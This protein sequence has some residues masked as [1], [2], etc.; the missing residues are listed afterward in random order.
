MTPRSKQ[1]ILWLVISI[2]VLA[3]L[4]MITPR[5]LST[6]VEGE[7][8]ERIYAHN[9]KV[10]KV[11]VDL[12]ARSLWLHDLEWSS[13]PDT[14]NSFPHI[15]R[16]HSIAV[17]R[18]SLYQ[19]IKNKTI[20]IREIVLDS[21]MVQPNSA[22]KRISETLESTFRR[23]ECSSIVLNAVEVEIMTDTIVSLSARI[24]LQLKDIVVS[25]DTSN[26][27]QYSIKN[28]EGTAYG[29]QLSRHEGMYGGTIR[30]LYISTHEGRIEFDSV[31]LIPNYT[32]YRFAQILG[33]QAGR[34]NISIP[35]LI[36]EGVAFEKIPDSAFIVSKVS[37]RSLDLFS[38]K[39]K[40]VP[41][42]R[43]YTIPLPM[44]GFLS[45]KWKV[46][47]D[48]VQLLDSRIIIEE[49][50]EKGDERT[51]ITFSDVNALLTGL[52]NQKPENEENYAILKATGLLMG[53]GKIE[54]EF[55][56]PLDGKSRYTA[57]GKITNFDLVKLN[58]VFVPIANIRIESG[59]LNIL[60]F[61][62]SYTDYVSKGKLDI[63]YAGLRLLVLKKNGPETNTFKTFVVN[64][65]VKKDRDQ[66][67]SDARAVGVIDIER[68]RKRLIFNVWWKS[69]LDGL[70]SSMTG[71]EKRNSRGK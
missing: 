56:L 51:Q 3:L 46:K 22:I 18:I 48:T 19:L 1:I 31:L 35:K 34:L 60:S 64:L 28:Y 14:V 69:I 4:G 23:F 38:F 67:G 25:F 16:I 41:F 21:G 13:V 33:E 2:S 71:G 63:D 27:L 8:T 42:L 68:D 7:I 40:R 11:T 58:P 50:P 49:Y 62:F 70:K 36:L 53:D 6:Y 29:I 15:L 32:K 55:T 37:I 52:N 66:S 24:D 57:Q 5:V 26:S 30:K 12:F 47:I 59:Y 45:A 44:E 10:S 65:F 54:A 39:D 20:H 43:D 9:G 17:K 61:D